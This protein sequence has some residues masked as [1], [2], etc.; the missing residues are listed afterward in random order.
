MLVDIDAA[1]RSP[2]LALGRFYPIIVETEHEH[3]EL[4]SYF[5]ALQP[6]P[7]APD[8]LDDRPSAIETPR[9]LISRYTPPAPGWP[10]IAVTCWPV[11]MAAAARDVGIA[12]ARG[13]YTMEV[14][15]DAAALDIHCATLLHALGRDNDLE[16]RMLSPERIATSGTA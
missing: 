5:S 6:A 16:L 8:L 3:V 7:K 4:E 2:S 10:W 12:M 9:I 15:E 14:F 1:Y 13:R 11:D